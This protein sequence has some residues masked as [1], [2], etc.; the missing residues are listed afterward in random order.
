M[1]MTQ[2]IRQCSVP[3]SQQTHR[4]TDIPTRPNYPRPN[5][6]QG[7]GSFPED[8]STPEVVDLVFYD[9]IESYVLDALVRAGGNYTDSDVALYMPEDF[10]SNSYLPAYAMQYWRGNLTSCPVGGGVG[11]DTPTRR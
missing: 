4:S 6:V 2:F 7:N 3:P 10:T 8:G 1:G 5:V 11:F 9:F